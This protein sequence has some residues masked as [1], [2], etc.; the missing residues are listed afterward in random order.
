LVGSQGSVLEVLTVPC[1]GSLVAENAL[2]FFPHL[3]KLFGEFLF[4]LDCLVEFDLQGC[5]CE[6]I[7]SLILYSGSELL[8]IGIDY[9]TLDLN[10]GVSA[11]ATPIKFVHFLI[12]VMN[13]DQVPLVLTSS[14]RFY[15]FNVF[16]VDEIVCLF[17]TL[18]FL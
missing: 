8:F 1:P 17:G 14:V 5:L 6:C 12:K 15:V 4:A 18:I 10:I 13:R 3:F 9:K 2:V 7:F 11:I 16:L